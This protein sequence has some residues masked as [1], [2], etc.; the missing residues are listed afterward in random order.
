MTERYLSKTKEKKNI[1]E[2]IFELAKH[3]IYDSPGKRQ[4]C[5]FQTNQTEKTQL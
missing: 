2:H 5:T 1:Q 4:V 3:I